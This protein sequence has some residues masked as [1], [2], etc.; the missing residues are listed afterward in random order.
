MNPSPATL[1]TMGRLLLLHC[2]FPPVRQGRT[3]AGR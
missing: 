1:L 3:F 2:W